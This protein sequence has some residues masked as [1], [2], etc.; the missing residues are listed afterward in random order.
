MIDL[1]PQEQ[2]RRVTQLSLYLKLSQVSDLKFLHDLTSLQTLS[3][4]ATR[5]Q[6]MSLRN[7]PASLVELSF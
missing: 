6:R 7:I 1:Q 4:N 5:T 2:L 3:I